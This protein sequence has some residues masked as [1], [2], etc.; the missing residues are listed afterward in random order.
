MYLPSWET[1]ASTSAVCDSSFAEDGAASLGD[2]TGSE[3]SE[4]T[5]DV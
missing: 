4:E 1:A 5:A 2:W 3:V